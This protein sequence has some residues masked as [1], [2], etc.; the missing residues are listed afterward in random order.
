MGKNNGRRRI[1]RSRDLIKN[2]KPTRDSLRV[3]RGFA[4][5]RPLSAGAGSSRGAYS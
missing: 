5:L 2:S 4:A 3:T 1:I